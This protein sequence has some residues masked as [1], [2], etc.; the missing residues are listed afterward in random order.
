MIRTFNIK[1]KEQLFFPPL[2]VCMSDM[3]WAHSPKEKASECS[4][5][6]PL[7]FPATPPGPV[8]QYYVLHSHSEHPWIHMGHTWV[9]L[10]K[11]Q[12]FTLRLW[13]SSSEWEGKRRR[14]FPGVGSYWYQYPPTGCGSIGL[15]SGSPCL[16]FRPA[17]GASAWKLLEMSVL[18]PLWQTY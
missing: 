2:V 10:K 18:E 5:I 3:K 11:C 8:P 17:A 15:N 12:S 4:E 1:M 6:L 9:L 7:G 16:V 13:S 14:T